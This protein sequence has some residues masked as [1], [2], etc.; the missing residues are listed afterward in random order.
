MGHNLCLACVLQDFYCE[1]FLGCVPS[2]SA[3]ASFQ[4]VLDFSIAH[5]LSRHL[6]LPPDVL[7]VHGFVPWRLVCRYHVLPF[8]DKRGPYFVLSL[9]ILILA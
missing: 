4:Y 5:E 1:L 7:D 3:G 8:L 2:Q 6:I 9:S